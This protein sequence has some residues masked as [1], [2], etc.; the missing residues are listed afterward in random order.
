MGIYINKFQFKI[1]S[2]SRDFHSKLD[3]NSLTQ[4]DYDECMI[5]IRKEFAILSQ[6][7]EEYINTG[8]EIEQ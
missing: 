4:K 2:L 5:K 8:L 3:H 6:K 1:D 7:H